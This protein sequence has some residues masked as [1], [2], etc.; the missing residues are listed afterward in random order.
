AARCWRKLATALNTGLYKCSTYPRPPM[1]HPYLQVDRQGY[2]PGHRTKSGDLLPLDPPD[3]RLCLDSK[4]RPIYLHY[5]RGPLSQKR[6]PRKS[7]VADQLRNGIA[8]SSL[9]D[10][11]RPCQ[12]ATAVVHGGSQAPGPETGGQLSYRRTDQGGIASLSQTPAAIG[13]NYRVGPL[14]SA[15]PGITLSGDQRSASQSQSTGPSVVENHRPATGAGGFVGAY[16]TG[17]RG[18]WLDIVNY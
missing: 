4:I 10:L 9:H 11:C 1:F 14:R 15:G 8:K 13:R 16:S 17:G 3:N 7:T 12:T 18:D 6:C 5:R 2:V